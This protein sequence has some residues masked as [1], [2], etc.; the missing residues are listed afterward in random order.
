MQSSAKTRLN[1]V[2]TLLVW[3]SN[4]TKTFNTPYELVLMTKPV[5]GQ[6]FEIKALKDGKPL[7]GMKI[8][9]MKKT[10]VY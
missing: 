10:Q 9:K 6:G 4:A 1:S 7:E 2:R 5:A 8:A 3:D